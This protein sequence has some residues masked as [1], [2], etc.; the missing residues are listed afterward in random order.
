M[1]NAKIALFTAAAALLS[2]LNVQANSLDLNMSGES[3]RL[4]YIASLAAQQNS[5]IEWDAGYLF[6]EDKSS[7]N[8]GVAHLGINTLGDVG[9]AP[10]K[11][12][13]GL[14]GRALWL[15]ADGFDPD[16]VAVA[17]GVKLEARLKGLDRLG[18]GGHLYYAPDVISFG[19]LDN[20]M[21]YQA[22]VG[23]QLLR[24]GDLYLRYRQV[25]VEH[26]TAGDITIDNGFNVGIK[27]TF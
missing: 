9:A 8:I 21:E 15:N 1:R 7:Q 12:V 27:L 19:D 18:F 25:K 3:V 17:I 26:A 23:Y 4:T 5:E 6:A 13:A 20:A 22:W 24:T 2:S 11:V 14:G 16:S 10:H